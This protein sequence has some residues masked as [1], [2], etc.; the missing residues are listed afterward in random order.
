MH[1]SPLRNAR[2]GVVIAHIDITKRKHAQVE[3]HRINRL[4]AVLSQVNQA[5]LHVG[6]QQELLE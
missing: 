3:L 4:Y 2:K 5:V 1:V 6:S